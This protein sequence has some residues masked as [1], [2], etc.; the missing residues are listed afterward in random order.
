MN[1]AFASL[2]LVPNFLPTEMSF[3]L[4]GYLVGR[5]GLAGSAIVM[6]A[7]GIIM[8]TI[9]ASLAFDYVDAVRYLLGERAPVNIPTAG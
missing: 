1:V 6:I 8:A 5:V 2:S 3:G 9:I 4:W 7:F